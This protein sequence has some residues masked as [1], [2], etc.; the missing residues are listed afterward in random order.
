M[1]AGEIC[2][3]G[4][5]TNCCPSGPNGG[6]QLCLETVLG[7]NRCFDSDAVDNCVVE[8]GTC[9]FADECCEGLCIP[10]ANGNL[11]CSPLCVQLGDA[12]TAD[13]D[14]CDGLCVGGSCVPD[15]NDCVP[16]GGSCTL[17][18]DCCSGICNDN[19]GT[20]VGLS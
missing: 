17:G 14:C 20:C 5:S 11:V 2:W 18:S 19:T 1:E 7:L 8:G 15:F 10:D 16:I 13:G 3:E 12:C 4:Q 6:Q 9:A